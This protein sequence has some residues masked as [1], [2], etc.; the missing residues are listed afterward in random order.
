MQVYESI[1]LATQFWIKG[2]QFSIARLLHD[3]DDGTASEAFS[4]EK[5]PS[6][7]W[8]LRIITVFTRR[9]KGKVRDI[10]DVPA[11]FTVNPIAIHSGI[12]SVFTENRRAILW[13]EETPFGLGLWLLLPFGATLVEEHLLVCQAWRCCCEPGAGILLLLEE[14]HVS[15]CLYE[16]PVAWDADLV[17]HG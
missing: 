8:R 9:W 12:Y 7:G 14:A 15:S 2:R 13:L 17:H 3:D 5:W 4:R 6:S 11:A 10:V 16:H 1:N